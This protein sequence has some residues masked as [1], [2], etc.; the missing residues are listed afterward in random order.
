L[1]YRNCLSIIRDAAGVP[2]SLWGY[3][4]WPSPAFSTPRPGCVVCARHSR[5]RKLAWS[6]QRSSTGSSASCSPRTTTACSGAT[7]CCRSTRAWGFFD[8]PR[9][10]AAYR[11]IAGSHRYDQYASPHT[12]AWRL[13]ILVWAA[14]NGLA[15][16]GDFVE[17]GVF[18]GDFA[19]VVAQATDFVRQPK[20]FYLYDTFDGFAP[21]YST[22]DDFADAPGFFDFADRIYR[23][24]AIYPEVVRRFSDCANI[25]VIRGVVPDILSDVAPEQIAFL[26]IDLNSPAAEIAALEILF[27]RVV[28]G[29]VIVFDDY[30]WHLFR[31]QKEAE[32]AFMAAR[33][34]HI[35]ELPTGQ[36]MVIKR[37]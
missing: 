33:G 35:L 4:P 3:Q 25:R 18:K 10:A 13:H 17:C 22:A 28:P 16:D 5:R 20:T 21:A 7:A 15:L 32:D 27:D 8:D 12:V 37:P 9:F 11:E 14:R 2:R 31:K 36:G 30:G 26:H 6:G 24:P 1:P 19:W 29:G 34:Y 23:D